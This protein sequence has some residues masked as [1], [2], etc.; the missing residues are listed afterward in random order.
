MPKEL[1]YIVGKN[2]DLAGSVTISNGKVLCNLKN[3]TPVSR[4]PSTPEDGAYHCYALLVDAENLNE[5][6]GKEGK[7]ELLLWYGPKDRRSHAS[8]LVTCEIYCLDNPLGGVSQEVLDQIEKAKTAALKASQEAEDAR[9]AADKVHGDLAK[10]KTKIETLKE[11]EAALKTQVSNLQTELARAKSSTIIRQMD[12]PTLADAI[13]HCEDATLEAL[14]YIGG[15]NVEY[16]KKWARENV[17]GAEQDAE[18]G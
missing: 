11:A 18:D 6:P 10:A 17:A 16:L 13:N 4:E 14:P 12:I 2:A 7:L 3:Y 9:T 8:S 1:V 15:Q 5:A